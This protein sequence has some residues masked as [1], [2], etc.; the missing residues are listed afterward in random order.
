MFYLYT[1]NIK[2]WIWSP[3]QI[4]FKRNF[5]CSNI[6]LGFFNGKHLFFATH[7]L[8]RNQVAA[9][10]WSPSLAVLP[11]RRQS[12]SCTPDTSWPTSDFP[13]RLGWK[14]PVNSWPFQMEVLQWKK[15][16]Y[17]FF[18]IHRKVS[19]LYQISRESW[20]RWWHDDDGVNDDAFPFGS[21]LLPFLLSLTL[22]ASQS[23]IYI[24]YI[25]IYLEYQLDGFFLGCSCFWSKTK[26]FWKTYFW[27]HIVVLWCC[28]FLLWCRVFGCVS[29][30]LACVMFLVETKKKTSN[31]GP[32]IHNY[33]K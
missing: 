22:A 29:P 9:G 18:Q 31:G 26:N 30:L 25:Y 15:L 1:G 14:K 12:S 5:L 6:N 16:L 20:W 17:L 33:C 2:I 3:H 8:R 23:P 27:C 13:R 4:T 11:R 32:G 10:L 7:P 28:V 24:Y 19:Y 21:C